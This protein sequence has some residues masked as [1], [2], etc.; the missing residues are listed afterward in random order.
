VAAVLQLTPA[1]TLAFG[2][3]NRPFLI[4]AGGKNLPVTVRNVGSA[5]SRL[6]VT[7]PSPP[8]TGANANLF[9][10]IG[11]NCPA[12]GLVQN[13]TCTITVRFVPTTTGPKTAALTINSNTATPTTTLNLTGTG[14]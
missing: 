8:I 7:L 2:N 6:I 5:G 4:F 12:A 9:S 10:I 14:V 3:T 13:A 11:N 1:G